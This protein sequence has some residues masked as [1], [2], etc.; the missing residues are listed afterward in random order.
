MGVIGSLAVNVV[1]RTGGLIRGLNQGRRAIRGFSAESLI[2]STV[3][4]GGIA[5]IVST[6]ESLNRSMTRS[7]AIMGNVSSGLRNDMTAAA[8]EVSKTTQFSAGQAAD[9]YFYLASAGLNAEQ[10]LQAMPIVA[11]F[12][13]AGNFDLATATSLSADAQSALGMRSKDTAENLRQLTRVT[14]I[15]VKANTLANAT[16]QQFSEALTNKAG[17]ALKIVGKDMVEGTAVLAAFADQGI[18]GADAGNALNIVFRELQTKSIKNAAL[19]KA[20]GVAVFDSAGE[21]RDMADIVSDL[22]SALG[23]L[24]DQQKKS[25]LLTLGFTDKSIAFIQTLV[26]TSEKIRGY[27]SALRDAGGTSEMVA[28]KSLTDLQQSINATRGAWEQFAHSVGPAIVNRIADALEMTNATIAGN[29]EGMRS[30]KKTRSAWSGVINSMTKE[31]FRTASQDILGSV[32]DDGGK[33]AQDAIKRQL[34]VD[35]KTWRGV[36]DVIKAINARMDLEVKATETMLAK[37]KDGPKVF[38]AAWGKVGESL[39]YVRSQALSANVKLTDF[40][41]KAEKGMGDLQK[42]GVKF[43]L[44]DAP[45]NIQKAAEEKH[46]LESEGLRKTQM[47]VDS[48]TRSVMTDSEQARQSIDQAMGLWR[49]GLLGADTVD[50]LITQ[51]D[52]RIKSSVQKRS[53]GIVE[54]GTVEGFRAAH[55][56]DSKQPISEVAKN[57][58]A[59]LKVLEDIRDGKV[60]PVAGSTGDININ[61]FS[62]V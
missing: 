6:Y 40:V 54:R 28:N 30:V 48:I 8:L 10:S 16:T 25:T 4:V 14:D 26:G 49:D 13:Q 43:S 27:E 57:S 36:D 12:A 56:S 47:E 52:D 34:G 21:M 58:R 42:A 55:G 61:Q 23:G 3:V 39:N 60:K 50:R 17:A 11:K 46:K 24:S 38:A 45:R 33:S 20:A 51:W 29:T 62:L 35:I 2:A 15:L 18:K 32:K 53:L 9:A 44:I 41:G 5:K 22:E 31:Q 7:L 19:F 59:M 1:A 37:E